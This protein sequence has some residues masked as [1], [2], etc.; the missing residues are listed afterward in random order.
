MK[1]QL[2]PSAQQDLREIEAWV[3]ENFSADFANRTYARLFKTFRLLADFPEMGRTRRELTD[4]P[5]R[6]FLRK[7]YWIVY[8]PGQQL[9]IHRVFHA[10]RG[11]D[12]IEL[13]ES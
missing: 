2:L 1:V 11:L 4:R 8:E 5:V 12:Q 13:G 3:T 7:P 6:F 9:M 10:A